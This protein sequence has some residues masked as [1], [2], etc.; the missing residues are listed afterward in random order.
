MLT[1]DLE[2]FKAFSRKLNAYA[3]TLKFDKFDRESVEQVAKNLSEEIDRFVGLYP[4]HKIIKEL[5]LELESIY[6]KA[7]YEKAEINL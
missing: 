6:I 2:D 7:I 3:A 4:D 1:K 5:A